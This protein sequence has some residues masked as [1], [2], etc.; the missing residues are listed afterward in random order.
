MK[1]QNLFPG[2][3]EK[4]KKFKMSSAEKF[5]QSAKHESHQSQNTLVHHF[6]GNM[7]KGSLYCLRGTSDGNSQIILFLNINICCG[8]SLEMPHQGT[9]N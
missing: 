9:S 7:K 1:S 5:T 6:S 2:K 3:N 4:R 8:Y